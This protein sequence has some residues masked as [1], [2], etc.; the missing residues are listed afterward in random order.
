MPIFV[1]CIGTPRWITDIY[2]SFG[3]WVHKLPFVGVCWRSPIQQCASTL[4]LIALMI[5][6]SAAI[7]RL[8][9]GTIANT[10][11]LSMRL[12]LISAPKTGS[13]SWTTKAY[14]LRLFP[15]KRTALTD[16]HILCATRFYTAKAASGRR[17]TCTTHTAATLYTMLTPAWECCYHTSRIG[18]GLSL[19]D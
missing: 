15:A 6:H 18:L 16:Q 7:E 5:I 12:E 10:A 14:Y 8:Y 19:L 1:A 3:R 17:W 11:Q 13:P 9:A 2:L 4:N